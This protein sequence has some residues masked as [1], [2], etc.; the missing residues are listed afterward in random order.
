MKS[1]EYEDDAEQFL[2]NLRVMWCS[3][4]E[5]PANVNNEWDDYLIKHD[6]SQTIF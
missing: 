1:G 6:S 3:V 4:G 5:R 2:F